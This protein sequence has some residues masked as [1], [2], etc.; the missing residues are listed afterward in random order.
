MG[1]ATDDLGFCSR[2]ALKADVVIFT[3]DYRLGPEVK[4]PTG[5]LDAKCGIEHIISKAGE[6]GIDKSKVSTMGSSGGG[7]ITL[8]QPSLLEEKVRLN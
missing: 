7:W 2:L 4:A 3:L 1:H 5:A 8:W 6:F